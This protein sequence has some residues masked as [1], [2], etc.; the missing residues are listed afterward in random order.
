MTI[1]VAIHGLGALGRRHLQALA[2][3]GRPVRLSAFDPSAVALAAARQVWDEAVFPDGSVFLAGGDPEPSDVAIIATN[4]RERAAAATRAVGAGARALILEKVLFTRLAELDLV[5][6]LLAASGTRA[7]VNC[8]RRTYGCFPV[9]RRLVDGSPFSY[10]VD[11]AGWGM[12]CNLVHHLDEFAALAGGPDV[13]VDASA[14]ERRTIPARRAGYVEFLGTVRARAANGSTFEATCRDG[15]AGDRVVTI[16]AGG[17]RARISQS[18]ATLEIAGAAGTSVSP[19]DMPM[20]SR[21]TADHVAAIL[22]GRS[23]PLPDYAQ[24]AALHRAMLGAFLD[25][26]RRIA[27]DEG[28]EECPIT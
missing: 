22:D 5:G 6:D 25:H 28:I 12:G 20:Q 24:A 3:L 7:W 14:L 2:R 8:V 16:E 23:P 18:A 26:L 9:L 21:I 17:T 10:R 13:E 11:G 19:F 4:A 1:R 15:E 27:G